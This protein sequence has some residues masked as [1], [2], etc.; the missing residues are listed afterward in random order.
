MQGHLA[1]TFLSTFEMVIVNFQDYLPGRVVGAIR[2]IICFFFYYWLVKC[3]FL[4]PLFFH[5]T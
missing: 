2:N 3:Y 1:L 5:L 4:L